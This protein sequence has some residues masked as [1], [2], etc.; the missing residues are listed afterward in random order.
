MSERLR[1]RYR[2]LKKEN[3]RLQN[4]VEVI[5]NNAGSGKGVLLN[6]IARLNE[7]I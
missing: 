2:F 1:K 3:E 4:L 5:Q 7:I 6:E